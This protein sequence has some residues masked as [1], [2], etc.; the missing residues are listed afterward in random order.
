MRGLKR[1]GGWQKA[2]QEIAPHT[3]A[4]IET[5]ISF[6]RSTRISSHLIRV[7]GLKRRCQHEILQKMIAPHT[8]AWIE[9]G[10]DGDD[11]NVENR[12]SYGCVD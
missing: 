6:K 2:R 10:L 7:R 1:A 12:T 5:E 9:T 8:G 3:G 11:G 4:W